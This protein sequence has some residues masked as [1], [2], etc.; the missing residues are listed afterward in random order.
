M[1]TQQAR[2]WVLLSYRIPREPSTPR[3]AIWRR[4]RRLGV[5]QIGDGLVAL[6]ADPRTIEHL[7]WV[8][9]RVIDADGT[10]T[11]WT[12]RPTENKDHEQLMS[13]MV[14]AR[15][16]EYE[17]LL[18]EIATDEKPTT[19]RTLARW[20]RSHR[21]IQR[22]DYFGASLG[23]EVR[24]ALAEMAGADSKTEAKK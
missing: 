1:V 6:P 24:G 4:L 21:E 12:A 23:D 10:A 3:I 16:A 20:R 13:D 2:R 8:A 18:G 17:A 22:R 5:A 19:P 7:E 11:V 14:A 15:D 9:Q